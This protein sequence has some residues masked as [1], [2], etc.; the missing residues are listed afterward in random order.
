MI[1]GNRVYTQ[2]SSYLVENIDVVFH[3]V[4]FV[5]D[6]I[7]CK[8]NH[9]GFLRHQQIHAPFNSVLIVARIAMNV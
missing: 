7:A 6:Q 9:I 8:K 3:L 4:G 2:W 5:I 1:A